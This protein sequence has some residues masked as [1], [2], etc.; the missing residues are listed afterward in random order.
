MPDYDVAIIGGGPGGYVAAI[1]ARQ[2]GLKT[3]LVEKDRLGG[4]CLNMGCIPTKALLH[5]AEV[6]SLVQRAEEFGIS[7]PDFRV[8]Y[9][10][11]F[12]RSRQVAD[13]LSQGVEF[14]MKKNGVAWMPGEG[15]VSAPEIVEVRPDGKKIT[16]K[17][18]ILATGSRATSLPGLSF[19]GQRIINS[20]HAVMLEELPKSIIIVG[21]GAIGMEFA[22]LFH[23]YGCQVT[24]LEMLPR[25]VPYEDEEISF[26]LEKSLTKQGIRIH[27]GTRVE[28]VSVKEDKVDVAATAPRGSLAL[29]ADKVLIATGRRG[30]SENLGLEAL[31]VAT[32][33]GFIKV[34]EYH[35]TNVPGIWAIGDVI[36]PPLLAHKASHEGIV[37]VEAIA[38]QNPHPVDRNSIPGCTFTDPPVASI[39]LTEAQAKE[40]G[41]EIKV[42]RFPFLANGQALARA[43]H[44]GLIKIISDAKYGELL[45]AHMIGPGV[46]EL[47]H[48]VALAKKLEGTPLDIGHTIHVHPT[49]S[50]ALMEAALDAAGQVIH[51]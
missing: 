25:I 5:N 36:G 37:A 50:E 28:T 40:A 30:N 33:R 42:G 15:F 21:A 38:G 22:V 27:T 18:I 24:V 19:D 44:E 4:V 39:G 32:E 6:L 49:L 8:D 7:I 48:E 35:R 2:L 29:S 11:A 1:R 12:R 17:N 45:G 47:I 51:I 31:G 34:D 14:L 16:A 41:Y 26:L 46:G 10:A 20:D 3:A 23:T 13:R 9:R 43:E